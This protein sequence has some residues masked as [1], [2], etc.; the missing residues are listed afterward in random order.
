MMIP[1]YAYLV[2]KMTC[3][4]GVI[5]IKGDVKRAYDRGR[6]S[7]EIADM[8]L[9]STEVQELRTALA[10]FH[11]DPIMPEA[12]TSKVSIQLEDNLSKMV[13]LSLDE[14]SKVGH[15]GSGLDPK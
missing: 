7:Y 8:L 3:T 15:V 12:K 9:A 10:E 11:L 4:N 5:Y 1:Q 6:E 13:P 2:L 14:P